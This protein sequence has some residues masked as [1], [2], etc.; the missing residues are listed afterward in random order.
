MEE[1]E[2]LKGIYEKLTEENKSILNMVAQ[3]M[4]IAQQNPNTEILKDIPKAN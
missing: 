3:G 4:E 2:E 1:K